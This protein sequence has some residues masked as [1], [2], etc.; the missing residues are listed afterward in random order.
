MRAIRLDQ[1]EEHVR[2]MHEDR[3]KGFE[4]EYLVGP[5]PLLPSSPTPLT[6]LCGS[7]ADIQY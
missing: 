3:D 1:F 4:Q 7:C 6:L 2:Q 5:P